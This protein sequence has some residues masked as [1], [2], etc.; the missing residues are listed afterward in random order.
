MA[1]SVMLAGSQ[2]VQSQQPASAPSDSL[3]SLEVQ[4]ISLETDPAAV[5]GILLGKGFQRVDGGGKPISQAPAPGE[6]AF[7]ERNFSRIERR[8]E[9]VTY[10]DKTS[11]PL[12][13]L[14]GSGRQFKHQRRIITYQRL[15]PLSNVSVAQQSWESNPDKSWFK[16][17]FDRVCAH[18]ERLNNRDVCSRTNWRLLANTVPGVSLSL[19]QFE[20][21]VN[22]S[23]AAAAQ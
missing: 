20:T 5:H 19:T 3:R 9:R 11:G 21:A 10:Q 18:G 2:A 13:P 12:E 1:V 15:M 17:I 8:G 14:G 7:Y 4:G 6:A 23:R 16:P 22:F